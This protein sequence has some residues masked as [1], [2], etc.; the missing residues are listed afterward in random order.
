MQEVKISKETFDLFE[1]NTVIDYE[2]ARWYTQK[3]GFIPIPHKANKKNIKVI[4]ISDYFWGFICLSKLK[5][6]KFKLSQIVDNDEL[7]GF[8]VSFEVK[9]TPAKQNHYFIDFEC[10]TVYILSK[11]FFF[12]E[13]EYL[14]DNVY[15]FISDFS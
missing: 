10:N 7:L 2:Q 15:D 11:Q 9:H 3:G 8:I 14:E 12:E 4:F 13:F 1:K 5:I 6:K